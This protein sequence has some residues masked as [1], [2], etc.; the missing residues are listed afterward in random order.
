MQRGFVLCN[1]ELTKILCIN[2]NGNGFTLLTINNTKVLNKA[3]C[4][5]DLT[6]A[7]NI[8]KRLQ[9]EKMNEELEITN[10]SALYKNFY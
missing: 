2:K 1:K 7:K 8:L 10:I 3:M 5:P 4:L 9:N 6:E